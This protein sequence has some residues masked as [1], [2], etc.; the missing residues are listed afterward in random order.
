MLAKRQNFCL[1]ARGDHGVNAVLSA[2]DEAGKNQATDHM[3]RKAKL[4][5]S[6]LLP[7]VYSGMRNG[8]AVSYSRKWL[9][10][11]RFMG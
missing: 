8:T 11:R 7:A 9:Q 6:C 5:F 4:P 3:E 1:S 10:E 2:S